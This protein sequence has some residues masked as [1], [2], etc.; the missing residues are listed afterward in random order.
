MTRFN[1]DGEL[2]DEIEIEK[3]KRV[4]LAPLWNRTARLRKIIKRLVLF[5]LF[6]GASIFAGDRITGNSEY[7]AFVT[8]FDQEF[9]NGEFAILTEAPIINLGTGGSPLN[10]DDVENVPNFNS[11]YIDH[12]QLTYTPRKFFLDP[13]ENECITFKLPSDATGLSAAAEVEPNKVFILIPALSTG[14][15]RVCTLA[16]RS[17]AIAMWARK[18]PISRVLPGENAPDT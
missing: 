1:S 10:W 14:T 12:R 18:E 17:V 4:P 11:P 6:I 16:A 2:V 5:A 3:P 13:A 8:S 7:Q 9:A 15:T